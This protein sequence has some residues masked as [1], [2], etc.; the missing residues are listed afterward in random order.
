MNFALATFTTVKVDHV[1]VRPEK[2]GDK[3][4]TAVDVRFL[5]TGE[6]RAVLALLDDKLCST[7]YWDADAEAGQEALPDVE[8]SLPNLR[9]ARLKGPLKWEEEI[10]SARVEIDFGMGGESNIVLTPAKVNDFKA[11]CQEGGTT[12][13]SF[14]VQCSSLPE[15]TLD[16]LGK[17]LNCETKITVKPPE[18]SKGAVIDGSVAGFEADYPNMPKKPD[19]TDIFAGQEGQPA[20]SE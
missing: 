4:V 16:K 2:H 20:S 5:L 14:R 15:G 17:L 8:A 10:T 19:A 12:E 1:N 3:S 18:V 7:L 11:D 9:F 13:L 6:N